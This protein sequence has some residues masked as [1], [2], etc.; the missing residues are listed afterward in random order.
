MSMGGLKNYF[1]LPLSIL[2]ISYV[3]QFTFV[4]DLASVT[5]ASE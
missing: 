5:V 4:T 3:Q 2:F 1:Y